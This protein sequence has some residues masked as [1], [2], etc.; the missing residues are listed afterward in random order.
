MCQTPLA[1]LVFPHAWAT[2]K[3]SVKTFVK[4][5]AHWG[6]KANAVSGWVEVA[7]DILVSHVYFLYLPPRFP[8]KRKNYPF[9]KFYFHQKIKF[10]SI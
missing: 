4:T 2:P 6:G 8:E 7:N 9:Q 1:P 10:V 3:P 5:S